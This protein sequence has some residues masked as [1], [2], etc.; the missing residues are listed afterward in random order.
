MVGPWS[1]SE[2]V[3]LE[4]YIDVSEEGTAVRQTETYRFKVGADDVRAAAAG[5][6]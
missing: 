2:G 6:F 4:G 5:S 1:D 3:Q